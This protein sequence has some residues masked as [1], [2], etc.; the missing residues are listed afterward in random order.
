MCQ[1]FCSKGRTAIFDG[2]LDWRHKQE[3]DTKETELREV[4]D[5]IS[6]Q[7]KFESQMKE[8]VNDLLFRHNHFEN[9]TNEIES[10]EK[11][12]DGRMKELKLKEDEFEGRVKE[13]ESEKKHSESRQ[14]ELE[15]QEKQ[16]EEQMKEFQSKEE[17]FRGHVKEFKTKKK[18]FEERWKE[19]EFGLR[20]ISSSQEQL[21]KRTPF[22]G[23]TLTSPYNNHCHEVHTTN[24]IP[25]ASSAPIF[26][27]SPPTTQH[28]PQDV[29]HTPLEESSL[30]SFDIDVTRCVFNQAIVDVDNES[31]VFFDMAGFEDNEEFMDFAKDSERDC[32]RVL[33]FLVYRKFFWRPLMKKMV[34]LLWSK[35]GSVLVLLF[36]VQAG[37]RTI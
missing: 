28:I 6:K 27:T 37:G 35:L 8:L 10:K 14:K 29:F 19:L 12:L 1:R 30:P 22:I 7:K 5:N 34:F 20:H 18:Q 33:L 32:K 2:G 3:L 4:M 16:H 24:I 13:P 36:L 9:R 15:A 26:I 23:N 17:E 21:L 25:L 11:Q 31:Q